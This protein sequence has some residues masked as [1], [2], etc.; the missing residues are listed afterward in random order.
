MQ[1]ASCQTLIEQLK[2]RYATKKF[3]PARKIPPETWAALEQALV[4]TP[5][6]FG[7]QPWRFVVIKDQGIK[8]KLVPLSWKQTQPADCS[9]FVVFAA[10][11][12]MTEDDIDRLIRRTSEVRGAPVESLAGFRK[13]MIGT[14]V[15]PPAAFNIKHWAA[16]QAYIALGNFMTAA[17]VIGVDTC[18]MEGIDPVKYDEL[19]GLPRQ[20][21]TT[22]VACAAG[23][24]AADDKY[25]NLPKVRF[26]A[27]EVIQR[28]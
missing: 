28:F 12:C 11:E 26:P 5:S 19:L 22:I 14:L 7:L 9:H 21:Y 18:P 17:A 23:Y 25:A 3:D 13:M 24:R 8:E 15:P 27:E 1:P 2:W 6:S 20:G 10:R 16:L 4:L